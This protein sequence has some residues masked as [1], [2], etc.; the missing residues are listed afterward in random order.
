MAILDDTLRVYQFCY[1]YK[2]DGDS[3][4]AKSSL[5]L[6]LTSQFCK[7]L[8]TILT[9]IPINVSTS[10]SFK[11]MHNEVTNQVVVQMMFNYKSSLS[12]RV[13][14]TEDEVNSSVR[15]LVGFLNREN[16][17]EVQKSERNVA[18][19]VFKSSYLIFNKYNQILE[20]SESQDSSGELKH[21]LSQVRLHGNG[22]SESFSN[23]G[24]NRNTSKKNVF[25]N[26]S[27]AKS[28]VLS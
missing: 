11:S 25:G 15:N 2:M 27:N 10:Y 21:R 20:N 18:D 1:T 24:M 12:K 13:Y 4:E 6:K 9:E 7:V 22:S 19:E 23:V 14:L 28:A 17:E 16:Y 8:G 5:M 3:E 26:Q